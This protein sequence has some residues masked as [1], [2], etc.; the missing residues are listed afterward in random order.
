MRAF[1]F[2]E[3]DRRSTS[4]ARPRASSSPPSKWQGTERY[5][6]AYGQGVAVT[7]MQLAAAMNTIANGGTYVAPRLVQATIGRDG[8]ETGG[9]GGA[10]SIRC[11][12]RPVAAR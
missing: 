10:H 5:T 3:R 4:R 9:A 6:V 8:K 11:C 2:G 1:G 7:A 12:R